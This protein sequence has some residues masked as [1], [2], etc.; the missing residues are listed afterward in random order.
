LTIVELGLYRGSTKHLKLEIFD[1]DG[2][3]VV[4]DTASLTLT[5]YRPDGTIMATFT[6]GFDPQPDGSVV[7][8]ITIPEAELTGI[9]RAVWRYVD[10]DGNTFVEEVPFVVSDPVR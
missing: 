3:R 10:P 1:K 8:T 2:N 5:L 4:I 6:S 7:R 9:W